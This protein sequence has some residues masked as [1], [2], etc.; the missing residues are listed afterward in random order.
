MKDTPKIPPEEGEEAEPYFTE[1]LKL[2]PVK[3]AILRSKEGH[4]P[5]IVFNENLGRWILKI[6]E[7]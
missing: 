4:T 7:S 5:H 6:D 2:R 1:P 3:R